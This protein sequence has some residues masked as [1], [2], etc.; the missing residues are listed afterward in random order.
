M[1]QLPIMTQLDLDFARTK[2]KEA[3]THGNKMVL[4][5]IDELEQGFLEVW[6]DLLEKAAKQLTA[7]ELRIEELEKAL[8]LR[9]DKTIAYLD[10][11]RR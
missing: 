9:V 5:V 1:R 10:P 2:I 4:R 11:D 8:D 7:C 3:E 6:S